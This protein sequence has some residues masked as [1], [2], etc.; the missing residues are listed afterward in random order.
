[1]GVF[2]CEW[3]PSADGGRDEKNG[4]LGRGTLVLLLLGACLVPPSA[5]YLR[6]FIHARSSIRLL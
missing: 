2:A 4:A 1:M 3:K 5:L 6:A